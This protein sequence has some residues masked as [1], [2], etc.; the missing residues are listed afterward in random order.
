MKSSHLIETKKCINVPTELSTQ[1][2]DLS[3]EVNKNDIDSIR[4]S[5]LSTNKKHLSSSS[6][7]VISKCR[8]KSINEKINKKNKKEDSITEEYDE[9]ID[10]NDSN[11]V[12]LNDEYDKIIYQCRI[13]LK[14][15]KNC[16]GLNRHTKLHNGE[17]NHICQHCGMKFA[18][19]CYLNN[20][21]RCHDNAK[22]FVCSVC[23]CGFDTAKYLKIHALYHHEN[24]KFRCFQC[25]TLN[26]RTKLELEGHMFDVHGLT[27]Q[28]F[29]KKKSNPKNGHKRSTKRLSRKNKKRKKVK[30]TKTK[31]NPPIGLSS[32]EKNE[33][34]LHPISIKDDDISELKPESDVYEINISSKSKS[35]SQ[36]PNKVSTS[37]NVTKE[38]EINKI[39]Q[40]YLSTTDKTVIPMIDDNLES[41]SGTKYNESS[42]LVDDFKSKNDHSSPMQPLSLHQFENS[43]RS[44]I[45]SSNRQLDEFLFNKNSENFCNICNT[46]FSN[47]DSFVY[48]IKTFHPFQQNHQKLNLRLIENN[49]QINNNLSSIS[50]LISLN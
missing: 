20:H 48:H 44:R 27:K 46:H 8:K 43:D 45:S 32:T 33:T 11:S 26:F 6:N 17:R 21:I 22:P 12:N 36:T 3:K 29:E 5:S 4:T 50:N 30:I 13:C 35:D 42:I 47:R 9:T 7:P 10:K 37:E 16:R 2:S 39:S 15:L 25:P 31:E 14:I 24:T 34:I 18:R 19:F 1:N 38:G 40:S 23:S 28:E 41:V 49:N